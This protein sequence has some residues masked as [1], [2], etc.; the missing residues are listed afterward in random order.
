M[1]VRTPRKVAGYAD[2]GQLGTNDWQVKPPGDKTA[3][4]R[5]GRE[6]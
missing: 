6:E 4:E 1:V 2:G 3:F 5:V